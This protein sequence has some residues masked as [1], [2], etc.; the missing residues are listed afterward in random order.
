MISCTPRQLFEAHELIII[1]LMPTFKK[2]GDMCICNDTLLEVRG[3]YSGVGSL[4]FVGP[5]N[6]T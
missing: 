1:S 4:Q 3:Q 2:I 6:Q 5:K